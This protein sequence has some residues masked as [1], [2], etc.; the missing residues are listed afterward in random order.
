MTAASK[1]ILVTILTTFFAFNSA[2]LWSIIYQADM[3]MVEKIS[4]AKA[5]KIN[6][7]VFFI[8]ILICIPDLPLNKRHF[9]M[10]FLHLAKTGYGLN[11]VKSLLNVVLFW[12]F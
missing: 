6:F 4:M 2:C 7:G 10:H 11:D 5:T 1:P 8:T 3:Q 9:S 12:V